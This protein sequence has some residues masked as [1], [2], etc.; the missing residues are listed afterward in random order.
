M[1]SLD[2]LDLCRLCL[3]KDRVSVPIFGGE[4][5]DLFLK[6]AACLPVKVG[7]E[8]KLPKKICDDCVYKVELFYEFW[9]TTANAEKRLLQWLGEVNVESGKQGYV[10]NVLNPNVM[11]QEQST[12]N[13]L[14]GS[15]MQQVGEHQNNMGMSMMDNMGLGIPMMIPNTNQQ[16]Q[17]TSV[18]MDTSGSPAQNVQ[19]VPGPSSQTT[20]N[21]ISQNQTSSTQQEDEEESSEDDE[22]SDDECDGDEGLPVKEESEE[23]PN[24]RTIEPTTFVNVSLAC[25]EAGPSGLQQQKITDMPEMP[26]SQ[27]A[28]GDP[29]TGLARRTFAKKTRKE[30]AVKTNEF[31]VDE[32]EE[33]AQ[34]SCDICDKQ[35]KKRY[36]LR[37]HKLIHE[38][39]EKKL[40]SRED[41][42][43]M[44]LVC[45][46][47]E[48]LSCLTCDFRCNK[49]STMIGHLAENHD[50][51][52]K[53]K[54]TSKRKFSCIICGLI[55]SRK[56]TLRS[57]F[58]RKHTQQYEFP[59]KQ[60]GKE[61]KIKGDLTTHTRLNHQEPPV[62][63][64]V[65]GK[66]CR[67]SHSLYTHQKHAHFK[68]KFEC[69]V[70]HRR[71]VTKENLDQHVLTQHEKKEKC[72]CEECGKTFFEKHDFRKHMRIHTGDKPYRCTVC[73]RAF[74]THSSLSQHLLLHT[75]ERVYV[76][77]VCGKS[78]AQ[79]AGLICHRKIHSGTLPPLLSSRGVFLY[80][81][82]S[83]V[84]KK[85]QILEFDGK[86][87]YAFVPEDD[88]PL[89]DECI[90]EQ[91]DETENEDEKHGLVKIESLYNDELPYDSTDE[92]LYEDEDHLLN[93]GAEQ[94]EDEQVDVKPIILNGSIED[95]ADK[96]GDL[97]QV[98]VQGSMV[99]IEKLISAELDEKKM[100][101]EETVDDPEIYTEQEQLEQLDE[102]EDPAEESDQVEQVEYLE[103]EILEAANNH[104]TP[105]KARRKI[106]KSSGGALK[107]KVCSEMFSSAISFRKHVAW[108]HK[109]K[110]CIQEDGAY[111]C[112]VCDYRTLK[113]SLFAAHLERKHETWS[114]KRPNNMLFPCATCGFVCRS[115][116]SLQ[117]HFIRKHTDRYEHQCK[118]CPKEFKVKGD[119]TNHVRFHH[120]EKPINCDVCGK[121]CQNSGS[122]YVHQKWAHYKPKY[123]CHIC[124]RRMVTQE[125]LDQHLLT[126]H[127][128]REKIVCAECGKTFTKK[129]SF[130]R[131]MAVHTGCKPHSCVICNK[132]FARRS[133]LRQ[134]LLIHTGKRPFVCDIC[135]KAFTQ[136]PGL[137]CHR[138]THPGPHP[139][140][141]VM[142][143]ADIVKEFTEGYVQE[144]NARENEEMIEDETCYG[145]LDPLCEEYK[146]YSVDWIEKENFEAAV[147]NQFGH[148]GDKA[149]KALSLASGRTK[150]RAVTTRLE[151][152]HCCRKFLKKS[153]LAEHLKKH[154]HKC[155]EC[156]KTFRLRRYLATHVERIHRQQVYDCSVCD[157]KSNN[158]GTLKNHYIRLHTSNYNFACD[159]CGKQFKIKKAL[160]HHVK[161]NH[162]D[163]PPIVCDVCGHFS[164]NLHALKA[165]MKYR[166]YKP[167][168]VCRICRRGMTTQENL[169]QHLTWHETREK[170]LCPTCGKRF[171]GRDLDSHMRVHTGVKPFPC[172]VCGKS[173]RRQTAQEQHVLIHTGKRPYVCDIC[174]QAFAQKPGL[175]CHRKRHPGPLP[176]LPVVSI[177]N[178]VTDFRPVNPLEDAA[179]TTEEFGEVRIVST[180][181]L[182]DASTPSKSLRNRADRA[183]RSCCRVPK[184]HGA[185]RPRKF[186]PR[187]SR[188]R[189]RSLECDHCGKRFDRKTPLILHIKEHVNQCR[190][191]DQG[192]QKAKDL[193]LHVVERHGPLVYPCHM[194]DFKSTNKWILKDHIIRR[195]TTSYP[196]T[197]DVCQK[198][199]KLKNDLKQHTNQMHSD[200]PAVICSVCGHSYKSVPALR[201]HMRYSHNKHPF[202]CGVCK[203]CL[204][205]QES[206]DQHML[207]H[208]ERERVVCPTC[209]KI[210]RGRTI[211]GHMRVHTG[212]KPFPCPICGRSFTRQTAMEQH[213][214]IHTGKRPYICDV[215][216]QAFAQKPGLICHRKRHPG[217]LPPLPV[218]S[219]K[220][221]VT[222]FTREYVMKNTAIDVE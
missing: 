177:K 92:R 99:T 40:L 87:Y 151:C 178:I 44:E 35:F 214:L 122:L 192:F 193:R 149:E 113:K 175:I 211:E 183:I 166:H 220:N 36:I 22:N 111:I 42:P 3:V 108:T 194:C 195:H 196:Y 75:G 82:E 33:S 162:S 95:E 119:L 213:V 47:Q 68:A 126:Q 222:E 210:L 147:V 64:D 190:F 217:P 84:M 150:R 65:C 93:G 104:A 26:I 125:N 13:R 72:V 27:S 98:K 32:N 88:T 54:F 159:V 34:L 205:T 185:A 60:C 29:K 78:F 12:E 216:G 208:K 10:P 142:P 163:A 50:G 161:Q 184:D 7:R 28:D 136:K 140:L 20:H 160:N 49:R 69:P 158:K 133:Q 197:C 131:H 173:F 130:K 128:K 218:V 59:C 143:I 186:P 96:I 79:K 171:R 121:L 6:I 63:C 172:P 145:I 74:T 123:E 180:V 23:D 189:P 164:K 176:P 141:P 2:Y 155:A 129:D 187:T 206:L 188:T 215:C 81:K 45:Q 100:D 156:P 174:G 116:H 117:S 31:K 41:P 80:D 132:P 16:Q 152:E 134:H 209:G 144:V 127:E 135:G 9:N 53:S 11:K 97:Y 191:C 21:Q 219:V 169:E 39:R 148:N 25:D 146:C 165:H 202:E 114:R 62:I 90:P 199:F 203:R 77:D 5:N 61:F 56:E 138:K 115:K 124:K 107:C 52:A 106:S 207:W 200:A 38:A 105:S 17:I 43:A 103:E 179:T 94:R 48:A 4:G 24:S 83:V 201:R 51:S 37:R 67:N 55:C 120:K 15:V 18:P 198:K 85:W 170:V 153:N 102:I 66:T 168:F 137:I 71:L 57:H 110:V 154:R 30:A 204:S 1:S 76:C 167:E 112:A 19:A 8:D 73:A 182:T 58:V 212:L 14:D 91:I 70:C 89:P 46:E 181:P 221:I 157:Y 139:P 86:P 109:K 118:F 101:F